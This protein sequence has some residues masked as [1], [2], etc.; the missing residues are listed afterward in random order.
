VIKLARAA[1]RRLGRPSDLLAA[2]CISAA[3]FGASM[4]LFDAFYFVQSTLLFFMILGI[5]FRVRSLSQPSVDM[6]AV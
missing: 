6:R 3:G 4:A 1:R 5:G 2:C